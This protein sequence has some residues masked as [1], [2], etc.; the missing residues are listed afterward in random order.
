MRYYGFTISWS[1][2]DGTKTSITTSSETS[3]DDA[4]QRA[5]R[6]AIEFGW[7]PPKWWQWWRWNE[8]ARIMPIPCAHIAAYYDWKW[9]QHHCIAYNFLR[10]GYLQCSEGRPDAFN[11]LY[12]D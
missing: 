5:F 6:D 4:K 12:E 3:I 9:R 10:F 11:N 2:F 1:D 7:T 8:Y